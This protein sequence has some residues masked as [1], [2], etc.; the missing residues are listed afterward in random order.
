MGE[1]GDKKEGV[2][3]EW[4]EWEKQ[5]LSKTHIF[6][7]FEISM[8]SSIWDMKEYTD[9]DEEAMPS[10]SCLKCEKTNPRYSTILWQRLQK[11]DL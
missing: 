2:E 10:F 3:E 9:S 1:E 8:I 4:V 6:E 7:S 5:D 11:K